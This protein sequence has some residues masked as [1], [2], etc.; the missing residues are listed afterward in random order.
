M[1][2]TNIFD[3]EYIISKVQKNKSASVGSA[4]RSLYMS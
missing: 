4:T 3:Y 2:H 1:Q